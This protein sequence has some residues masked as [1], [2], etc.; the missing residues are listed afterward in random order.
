MN[1]QR[2]RTVDL[3]DDCNRE[4]LALEVDTFLPAA[5]VVRVLELVT[6]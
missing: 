6:A 2:F 3:P 1:D 5:R 4:A